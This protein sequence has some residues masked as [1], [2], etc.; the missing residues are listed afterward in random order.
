MSLLTDEEIMSAEQYNK[1]TEAER[2][3][4][5]EKNK[6][7]ILEWN[8]DGTMEVDLGNEYLEM[9]SKIMQER[10]ISKEEA[11][12]VLIT[13]PLKAFLDKIE[14]DGNAD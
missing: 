14:K 4:Y 2:I 10:C 7:M 9:L 11:L 8:D 12:T 6:I 13:E 5:L 1:L 3:K